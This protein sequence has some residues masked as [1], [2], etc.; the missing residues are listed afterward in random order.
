[1]PHDLV[2]VVHGHPAPQGSKRHVGH[3]VMVESSKSL[4]AWRQA[5]T[6]A[7][8]DAAHHNAWEPP[9]G[10][11]ILN[12]VF[13]LPRPQRP[14]HREPITRPD[15]DKLLR[16]VLDGLVD[17]AVIGDDAQVT[18]ITAAKTYPNGHLDALDH[19]GVTIV[20][21]RDNP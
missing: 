12:V 7:A 17:A 16:G 15:L 2:V 4:P 20:L 6:A 13:T 3:G 1:M 18:G 19:P 14:R 8:I 11:V 9:T 5:V 10:P 21:V